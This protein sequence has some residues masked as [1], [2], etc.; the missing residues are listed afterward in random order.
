MRLQFRAEYFNLLNHT[1]LSDPNVSQSGSGFGS[2]TAASDPRIA[3][4]ALK[5]L[6]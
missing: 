6:F 1:N 5:L 3:Q 2:V 4:L